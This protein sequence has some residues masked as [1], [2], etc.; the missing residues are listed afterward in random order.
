MKHAKHPWFGD[1]FDHI[2]DEWDVRK[3]GEI[4]FG[5]VEIHKAD[6]LVF[7]TTFSPREVE[8]KAIYT[9]RRNVVNLMEDYFNAANL[10]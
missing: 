1:N 2:F 10:I 8:F 5:S 9:Y 7:T 4:T 6:G 3:R